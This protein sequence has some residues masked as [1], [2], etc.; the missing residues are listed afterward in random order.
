MLVPNLTVAE[1]YVLGQGSPFSMIRDMRA[2]HA[3]ILELSDRYGLDVTPD[4]L[5]SSLSVGE[6]QRVE[7]LKVLYH[8]IELLILD[9]PTAV[10][11]PQETDRLLH[12]LRQLVADGKT[13]IFI[14]HKLDE[15]MRVSDRVSVMRDAK[16]ETFPRAARYLTVVMRWNQG[17][18]AC[19]KED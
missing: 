13:V 11:T 6:R 7:I 4:A 15:V 19:P 10:L 8:G 12:L 16:E 2:V 17:I 5:V 9:E 18:Q 14:S 1:N 3:R